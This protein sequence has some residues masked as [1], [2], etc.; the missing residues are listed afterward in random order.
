M[1]VT[2]KCIIKCQFLVL[3]YHF[4]RPLNSNLRCPLCGVLNPILYRPFSSQV[5]EDFIYNVGPITV[6]TMYDSSSCFDACF[7]RV[8]DFRV[9]AGS[10]LAANFIAIGVWCVRSTNAVDVS[11]WFSLTLKS[12]SGH[13][14]QKKET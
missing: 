4:I 1:P 8:S 13:K 5:S 3:F 7:N 9:L 14:P 2:S 10:K 11:F 6:R 12:Y